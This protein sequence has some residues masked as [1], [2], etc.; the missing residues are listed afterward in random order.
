MGRRHHIFHSSVML[1]WQFQ[2]QKV[3]E[4]TQDDPWPLA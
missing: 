2:L 4:F 1:A 3:Y